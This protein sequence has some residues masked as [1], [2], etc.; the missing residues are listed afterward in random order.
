MDRFTGTIHSV[1]PRPV[2]KIWEAHHD[3]GAYESGDTIHHSKIAL[4]VPT[5]RQGNHQPGIFMRLSNPLGTVYTRMSGEEFADLYTFFR[6]TFSEATAALTQAQIFT[7]IYS[8]AERALLAET[9]TSK[10]SN[11]DQSPSLTHI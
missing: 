10:D 4:W 6:T 1:K 8:A 7:Q 3:T 5:P 9:K 2:P 11:T